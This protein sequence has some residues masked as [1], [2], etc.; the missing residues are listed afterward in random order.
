MYSITIAI[1]AYNEEEKILITL[2]KVFLITKKFPKS[3][4]EIIVID[5][6]STDNTFKLVSRSFSDKVKIIRNSKNIGLGES[7]K[8]G[9][10]AATNKKFMFIPAD[11]DLPQGII[12]NLITQ[13]KFA[14]IVM[15]YFLNDEIRGRLRSFLSNIFLNIYLLTFN[16]FLKYINGPAIYPT[17]ALKELKL[18]SGKFSIIAEINTKLLLKGYSFKEIYGYRQNNLD[19]STS[20]KFSSIYEAIKTLILLIL[21]IKIYSRQIYNKQPKRIF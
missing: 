6:G 18:I 8:K 7:I 15:T 16:L 21:E 10:I 9:I 19:K 3:N 2:K 4:F 5:D 13:S 17:H 11:D 1:P 14:D 20:M 12:E